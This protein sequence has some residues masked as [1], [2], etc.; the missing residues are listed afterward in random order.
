MTHAVVNG[1]IKI[2]YDVRGDGEPFLFIMGLGGQLTAWHDE[3]VDLFV[4]EGYQ[5]IRFD[6]RD[7]GLSTQGA[8]EPP[9]PT[10]MLR[11]FLTRRAPEGVP[12][13]VADMADDAA[14]L[15]DHLGIEAAHVMGIS[16]GGMIAQEL[17]IRHPQKVRS[18]CSIMSH[19]GDRKNGGI[20]ASLVR[21]MATDK[22]PTRDN[23]VEHSVEI[24][25]RFSGP[26]F[27]ADDHRA[28]AQAAIERSFTPAGVARQTAAI[29][30]SRDRTTLLGAVDVP[31]LVV[32]GLLDPLIKP[33][34]G[35][36]TTKAIPG[37]RLLA[38]ADMAHDLPRPR[39]TELRD[40]IVRNAQR[41]EVQA[42]A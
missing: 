19:T 17:T 23:A 39:W 14:G 31:T 26:H 30:A 1:D 6:N 42:T 37:S 11:S 24:F 35:E 8:W 12:Y 41:A 7:I 15:L 16:M 27:N 4:E 5:V 28:L 3:F 29:A 40:E 33:S 22:P 21:K 38:F 32:H 18:L 36:A 20:A 9:S 25:R 13:T 10:K 2:E 34:G